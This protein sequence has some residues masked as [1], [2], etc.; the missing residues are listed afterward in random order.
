MRFLEYVRSI[1]LATGVII[2]LI[3][4]SAGCTTPA[5]KPQAAARDELSRCEQLFEALDNAVE[6]AGVR[7]GGAAQVSGFPYLRVDRFLASYRGESM[8]PDALVWWVERMRWLD[9]ETRAIELANLPDAYRANLSGELPDPQR[10]IDRLDECSGKL[11]QRDLAEAVRQERLRVA[12]EVPDDYQIW[13]R[14]LGL[15]P[16]TALAF[17]QGIRKYQA[18]VRAT[19]ATPL[20][21]LPVTGR[22]IGY[23]PEVASMQTHSRAADLVRSRDNPLGVPI[24]EG[25]IL[26]RLVAA[27]APLLEVDESD[28]DDRIG[29]PVLD[30]QGA[31][32]IDT[33]RPTAF[34]RTA[35][36]R[37]LGQPL[38]QLV[39]SFW[40]PARPKM[41]ELDLLGGHL[42]AIVWRVTLD[43]NGEPL[44]YDTIHSCGC[45]HMFFPTPLVQRRPREPAFEEPMLVPARLG[46]R[47]PEERIVIR[48]ASGTHYIE[49]VR[50]GLNPDAEEYRN[51]M[52]AEDDHLRTLAWPGRG[53]R[54]LYRPDGIVPGSERGERYLY[55]P[56]GVREPGAMRQ[57]GRHATAFV[58][59][60]HFDDPTLIERYF[61]L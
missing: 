43:S 13:Q 24:P 59:R 51:Y 56:M 9:K 40:F 16:V 49:N 14:I 55:W 54:S 25:P 26:D 44:L 4:A 28:R 8:S 10:L 30:R 15:Y 38:L 19:F 31:A 18:N 33:S 61:A 27:N 35:H 3:V 52:F 1:P 47:Q 53:R 21:D 36:A 11:V 2:F 29:A 41:G 48:V 42:D 20:E 17:Y 39:Y 6:A 7:D 5:W 32:Y 60:R 37:Y 50:Y 58:G 34:V 45:Y 57:W 22:L 46:P 23:Q 12:A